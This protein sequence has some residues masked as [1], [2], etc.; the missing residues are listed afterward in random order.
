[1]TIYIGHRTSKGEVYFC[2]RVH[3]G[4]FEQVVPEL[5]ERDPLVELKANLFGLVIAFL[6]DVD[7]KGIDEVVTSSQRTINCVED[8]TLYGD[9]HVACMRM[10]L[11]E[12]AIK[13]KK[14]TK[15]IYTP[16]PNNPIYNRKLWRTE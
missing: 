7:S 14:R 16:K 10:I 6:A 11:R 8:G 3:H 12:V 13:R 1:M 9:T 15:F 4:T 5:E 2:K